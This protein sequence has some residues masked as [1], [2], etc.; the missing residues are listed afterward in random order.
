MATGS[1]KLQRSSSNRMIAGVCGGLAEWR[2]WN[3]TLVRILF[4]LIG[5]L[6]V[7][8]GIVAYLVLWLLVPLEE[9]TPE[10]SGSRFPG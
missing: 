8:P 6:P 1:N 5:A 10:N 7:L 3:P 9:P 4:V 2:G